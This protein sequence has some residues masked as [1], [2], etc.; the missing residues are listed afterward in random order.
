MTAAEWPLDGLDPQSSNTATQ[1]SKEALPPA[2]QAKRPEAADNKIAP[3]VELKWAALI[4]SS[5]RQLGRRPKK[6]TGAH[7]ARL[8]DEILD[9]TVNMANCLPAPLPATNLIDARELFA[10]RH[11]PLGTRVFHVQQPFLT[12]TVC[13]VAGLDRIVELDP[14]MAEWE[15]PAIPAWLPHSSLDFGYGPALVK[16]L[17]VH[18]LRPV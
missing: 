15:T 14:L 11:L 12:G 4:K 17:P 2:Y 16:L 10:A 3:T 7:R 6:F 9:R 18:A 5:R 8:N 13:G 1:A